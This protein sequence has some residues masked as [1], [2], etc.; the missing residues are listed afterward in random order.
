MRNVDH[1]G[2]DY[3]TVKDVPHAEACMALCAAESRCKAFTWGHDNGRWYAR[4]CFLKTGAPSVA[5]K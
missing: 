5:Y 4:T 2:M 3:R 1:G